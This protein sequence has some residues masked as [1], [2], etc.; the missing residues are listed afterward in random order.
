MTYILT[1]SAST[2]FTPF[3]I[4]SVLAIIVYIVLILASIESVNLVTAVRYV[5]TLSA[6]I[7]EIWKQKIRK[8]RIKKVHRLDSN[9][10]EHTECNRLHKFSVKLS[11]FDARYCASISISFSTFGSICGM[12]DRNW[13]LIS[14]CASP[15][16]SKDCPRPP[17]AS[18]ST[19][20]PDSINPL[21][22]FSQKYDSPLLGF[23]LAALILCSKLSATKC[24][25]LP[26]PTL[27]VPCGKE[28]T[29]HI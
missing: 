11:I 9:A 27:T 20:R 15:C 21:N 1:A 4:S 7:A 5:S 3:E 17:T 13:R 26:S 6:V 29:N 12:D 14:D 24:I 10:N 16:V 22:Y 28:A 8:P 19:K 2:F 25:I 23:G 18:I